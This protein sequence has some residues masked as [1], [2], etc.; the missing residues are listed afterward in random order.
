MD[1]PTTQEDAQ[2]IW[3]EMD[4]A[5]DAA[6]STS[7]AA[8]HEEVPARQEAAQAAPNEPVI[9]PYEGLP[10]NVRDELIGMKSLVS[11]LTGRLRNA[12]G[13]IGGLKSQL[14]Q[15]VDVAKS[16][17]SAG[18]EAPT[19]AQL[20]TAQ[21]DPEA[22]ARLREDYPEFATAIDAFVGQKLKDSLSTLA[23][24]EALSKQDVAEAM[25]TLRDQIERETYVELQHRGWKKLV[26]TPEFVGWFEQ[27]PR[28]VKTLGGSED[29]DDAV[30]LLDM[31]AESRTR[32]ANQNTHLHAAAAIPSGR[33]M[34][35]KVK[36]VDEMTPQEFW[37]YLDETERANAR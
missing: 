35:V 37:R 36:P 14:A 22:F 6:P 23:P 5:D 20:R 12:E 33:G 21:A 15:Q 27:Q 19:A 11:Q 24:A 25:N 30:R 13:H 1:K 29:P 31:F 10:Q 16:V 4:A 26:K 32:R 7:T 8:E 9:D 18:G 17:R 34:G 28:E 3:D 2:R